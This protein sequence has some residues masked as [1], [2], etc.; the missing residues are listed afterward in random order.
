MS[1]LASFGR[2]KKLVKIAPLIISLVNYKVILL[3]F[4]T[5]KLVKTW[6][7]KEF[8]IYAERYF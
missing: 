4:K 3:V 6:Q 8:S 1:N 5:P 7:L 2:Y